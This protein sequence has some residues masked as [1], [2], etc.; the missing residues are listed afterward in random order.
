[1]REV[2]LTDKEGNKIGQAEILE[3]HTGEGMLHRAF[4]IYVF[5]NNRS[6]VLIQKR[7]N[8]K[9]LFAGIWANTCCSHPFIDEDVLNAGERRLN[10]ECGFTA[11]LKV[12][13]TLVYKAEDPNGNGVE[14]E[15]VSLLTA[16]LNG[17][18]G[19]DP[20]P[21]E[22]EAMEWRD[23]SNLKEDMKNNQHA[24]APWFH[25]GLNIICK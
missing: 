5:R 7:A 22:I 14:Y 10:E 23:V 8:T 18:V 6:E 21:E 2:T 3:A 17:D 24:Y 20:N 9:L 25:L 13:G 16:D 19:L 12:E 15:H 1:M 4:S 11:H